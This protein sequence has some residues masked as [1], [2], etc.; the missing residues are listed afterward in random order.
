MLFI[1][2]FIT[3][4]LGSFHCIGMCGPIALALPV[5]KTKRLTL[6]GRLL[7]S[8]GRIVTYSLLG[9][10]AGTVGLG[11]QSTG[12]QQIV[13]IVSG[14]MVILV[15]LFFNRLYVF[16]PLKQLANFL[17]LFFLFSPW[18]RPHGYFSH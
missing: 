13:S 10:V 9:L 6:I 2:A 3:G 1:T 11:L 18:W 14:A 12:F 15:L 4:F 5:Q 8:M 16:A 17:S 7:Y